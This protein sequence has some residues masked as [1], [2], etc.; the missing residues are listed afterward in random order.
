MKRT[1]T[2]PPRIPPQQTWELRFTQWELLHLRDLF[3][4]LLPPD[5]KQTVSSALAAAEE[6][7]VVEARVWSK[8][9]AACKSAKI[10]LDEGAPDFIVMMSAA[11]TLGIF[12]IDA[13]VVPGTEAAQTVAAGDPSVLFTHPGDTDD[14]GAPEPPK[15]PKKKPRRKRGAA[16]GRAQ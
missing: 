7:A 10:P 12:K 11:P 6:R 13:E 14:G 15:P 1:P 3:S 9:S 4:I 16:K 8:V 5:G 2:T